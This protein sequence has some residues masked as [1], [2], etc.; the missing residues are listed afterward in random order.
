MAIAR[1]Q[2]RGDRRR[3][4]FNSRY[5]RARDIFVVIRPITVH[6]DSADRR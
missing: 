1:A 5:R 6:A 2:L 4:A 3:A